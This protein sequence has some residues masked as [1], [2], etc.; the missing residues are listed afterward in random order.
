MKYDSFGQAYT[1][2][3]ELCELLH[4]NPDLDI[5]KFLVEDWDRYNTSIQ[6][7][8]S[9]LPKVQEY[10]PLPANYDIDTFHETQ[11][12]RWYMPEQYQKLDIA[13]YVL[14]LCKT[15]PELQRAGQELLMFQER[16][17]FGLLKYLKY[18]VDTM[19]ANNVVWGLGRGSS[20][21]SYV[22]YLIG[23]HKIDSLYY[24]LSIEE[25]LK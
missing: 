14:S 7:T 4:K 17:L 12:S 10:H 24:D 23:V 21:A 3:D 13:E 2:T 25:F 6:Q 15:E 5:S 18:F 11:Q 9:E 16:N 8:Y 22:L 1:S 19:R 20:V